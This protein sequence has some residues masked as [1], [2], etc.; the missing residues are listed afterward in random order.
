[1]T[2]HWSF[3]KSN[4]TGATCTAGIAYSFGAIFSGVR[5]V[6]SLILC[7]EHLSIYLFI[8][9]LLWKAELVET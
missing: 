8:C 4:K 1:M 6:Q 5:V 9:F 2:Y 7:L 3:N